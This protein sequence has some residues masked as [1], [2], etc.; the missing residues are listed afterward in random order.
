MWDYARIAVRERFPRDSAR[1]ATNRSRM[2]SGI[3]GATHKDERS[4][5][6]PR[7]GRQARSRSQCRHSCLADRQHIEFRRPQPCHE[8]LQG[9]DVIIETEGPCF[10]RNVS[11]IDPIRHIDIRFIKQRTDG[12]AHQRSMVARLWRTQ[13]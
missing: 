12:S 6:R 8:S 7:T 1:G 9:Q 11:R 13:Q 4:E 10:A 2:A 5:F 3:N